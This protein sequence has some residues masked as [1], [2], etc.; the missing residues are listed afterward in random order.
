MEGGTISRMKASRKYIFRWLPALTLMAAI[1]AL[2]S[3]PAREMPHFGLLD[4]LV[5]KGG[6]MLGYGLLALAYLYG[7]TGNHPLRKR[8]GDE[9]PAGNRGAGPPASPSL[10]AWLLTVL[11]AISDE[12]HQSFVPGRHASWGDVLYDAAGA[13]FA[14]WI[15]R[16]LGS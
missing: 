1:F 15:V 13:F 8:S 16:R 12:F 11:Y 9:I 4:L 10:L 2:S 5:K 14:L 3:I 7:L 6:H